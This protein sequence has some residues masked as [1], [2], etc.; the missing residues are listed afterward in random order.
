MAWLRQRSTLERIGEQVR[1]MADLDQ[2]RAIT[3]PERL[4]PRARG[5]HRR[6]LAMGER[7]PRGTSSAPKAAGGGTVVMAATVGALVGA[8]MMFLL[9]PD[10]GPRR[11]ALVRDRARRIARQTGEVVDDRSRGV[12]KRA[13]GL[14][15]DLRS[16][17]PG[18][19]DADSGPAAEARSSGPRAR[20]ADA[21]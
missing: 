8:L 5:L 18:A 13:R 7:L 12:V 2:V 3:D 14:V 9:D 11:R 17:L 10:R 20:T 15:I 1:A 16:R 19:S 4:G 6:V 21:E